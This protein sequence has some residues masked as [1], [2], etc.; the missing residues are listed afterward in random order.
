MVMPDLP[1]DLVDEILTRVPTTSL[2]RFRSACKRWNSLFKESGFSEKQSRRAPKQHRVLMLK[3]DKLCFTRVNLKSVPPSIEF[4]EDAL[5]T[6][7][8]TNSKQG[9]IDQVQHCDG[10]L[11]CLTTDNRLVVW[12]PCLGQTRWIQSK[13]GCTSCYN[14]YHSYSLGYENKQSCRSYKVL[15][16]GSRIN[17]FEIY[18]LSSNSWRLVNAPKNLHRSGYSGVCL[19]GNT[20]WISREYSDLICFDFTRERFIGL[21]CLPNPPHR[22][23]RRAALSVFR[24]EGV[25]KLC[26]THFHDSG[27]V[28]MWVTNK[29]VDVE[30]DLSWSKFAVVLLGP[31]VNFSAFTSLL[32]DEE[33]KVAVCCNFSPC[34]RRNNDE[35]NPNLKDPWLQ[36]FTHY[37]DGNWWPFLFNYV[38]SLVHI[39]S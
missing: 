6:L 34:P 15:M 9:Y 29:I 26:Y 11:L 13:N 39:Q 28:E 8:D 16:F 2:I 23:R 31:S 7:K 30:A 14:K 1:L 22:R 20:Y 18:E 27:K 25:S 33:K 3:D 17:E 37:G 12:N 10:L 4:H 38:P 36:H 32:T 35:E 5:L 19:N 24:E 21:L